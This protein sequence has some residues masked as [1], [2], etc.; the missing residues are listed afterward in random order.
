[1]RKKRVHFCYKTITKN[2][3]T[4]TL[5]L[6]NYYKKLQNCY[7]FITKPLHFCYK[8][9]TLLLQ[10]CYTFITKLLHFFTKV[11]QKSYIIIPLLPHRVEDEGVDVCTIL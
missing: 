11:L 4:I 8:T 7:T 3:K 10:N 2:Y 6:Q 1:M 9:V 5:L